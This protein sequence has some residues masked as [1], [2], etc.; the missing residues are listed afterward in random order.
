MW[1]NGPAFVLD[2]S[3]ANIQNVL[4]S[5]SYNFILNTIQHSTFLSND[6]LFPL[7]PLHLHFSVAQ[8]QTKHKTKQIP[9]G[10]LLGIQTHLVMSTVY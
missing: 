1:L 8:K 7:T 9:V 3:A 5:I 10:T 4:E 2:V 6:Y